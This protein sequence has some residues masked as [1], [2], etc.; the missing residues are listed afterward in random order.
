MLLGPVECY[1]FNIVCD[2]IHAIDNLHFLKPYLTNLEIL[3]IF[4]E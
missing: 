3:Y 4:F 1:N 2:T